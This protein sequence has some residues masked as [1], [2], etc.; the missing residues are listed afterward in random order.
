MERE[1]EWLPEDTDAALEWQAYDRELCPGCK[2]LRSESCDP[3]NDDKYDV[4]PVTCHAC[5]RRDRYGRM[6]AETRGE[7]APP[8]AGEYYVITGPN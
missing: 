4:E 1:P 7:G 3:K 8:P 2:R 5:A 6:S